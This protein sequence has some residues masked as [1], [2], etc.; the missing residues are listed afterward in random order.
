MT[1]GSSLLSRMVCS[2]GDIVDPFC[3]PEP[4]RRLLR[5]KPGRVGARPSPGDTHAEGNDKYAKRDE[6]RVDE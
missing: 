3:H 2:R 6:K 5:G 4:G 1:A